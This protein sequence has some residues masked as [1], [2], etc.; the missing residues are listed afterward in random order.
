MKSLIGGAL[1]LVLGAMLV[2]C[3]SDDE[4]GGG[5][6][7]SEPACK[8]YCDAQQAAAC[9]DTSAECYE[10]ECVLQATP[11]ADCQTAR[12]NYYN[13]LAASADICNEL[14]QNEFDALFT[15]C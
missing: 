4:G 11:P 5:A 2:A 12:T 8:A 1:A 3:G 7:A 6:D 14:C 9:G 10:F 13:C 15:I